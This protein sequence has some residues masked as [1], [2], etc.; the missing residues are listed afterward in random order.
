VRI[1]VQAVASRRWMVDELRLRCPSIEVVYEDG[2]GVVSTFNRSLDLA[3]EDESIHFE[4]DCLPCSDFESKAVSIIRNHPGFVIQFFSMRKSDISKGPGLRAPSSFLFNVGF[5][6]P[7]GMASRLA[8]F[9]RSRG[10]A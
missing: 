3:G 7:K 8:S 2:R 10:D 6:M 5:Y 9:S 4:D 1:I